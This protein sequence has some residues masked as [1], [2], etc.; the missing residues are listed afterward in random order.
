MRA[1]EDSSGPGA[2]AV[3]SAWSRMWSTGS[4]SSGASA[5][6][7]AAWSPAT[8]ARP[9]VESPPSPATPSSSASP[10][11]QATCRSRDRG[12]RGRC[13]ATRA[14]SEGS[15]VPLA[16][17][18]P[19]GSPAHASRVIR[20]L[21]TWKVLESS[22]A[23]ALTP[24]PAWSR[25]PTR[26]GSRGEASQAT[27]SS[28]Q[29][30]AIASVVHTSKASVGSQ[31]PSPSGASPWASR[32]AAA[33]TSTSSAVVVSSTW[34]RAAAALRSRTPS[35]PLRRAAGGAVPHW[36]SSSSTRRTASKAA[37]DAVRS[38]RADARSVVA[39]AGASSTGSRVVRPPRRARP[40]SPGTCTS[41]SPRGTSSRAASSSSA[42]VVASPG[43]TAAAAPV[44]PVPPWASTWSSRARA[45][46]ESAASRASTSAADEPSVTGR[47]PLTPA[48]APPVRHSA[49]PVSGR[50]PPGAS[51]ATARSTSRWM[52]ARMDAG[53]AATSAISCSGVV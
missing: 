41:P 50:S 42:G 36:S 14:T 2:T 15:P 9:W 17:T 12:R 33:A 52:A 26:P 46:G 10:T 13:Q 29:R 51:Q 7:A 11:A 45:A 28:A 37:P 21:S 40:T 35:P 3:R 30:S 25:V 20:R 53:S 31:T 18:A 4:G 16:S 34:S 22:G 24:L 27:A 6:I 38:T 19:S 32:P 1:T 5:A 44:A 48:A 23:R 39:G 43:R 49:T 8:R 47:R